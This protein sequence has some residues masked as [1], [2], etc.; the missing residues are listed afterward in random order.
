M[1]LQSTVAPSAFI[2]QLC[3]FRLPI[4]H[5]KLIYIYVFILRSPIAFED[6]NEITIVYNNVCVGLLT[7]A[8]TCV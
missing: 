3:N 4:I 8:V 5:T 7:K 6:S 2:A 1:L